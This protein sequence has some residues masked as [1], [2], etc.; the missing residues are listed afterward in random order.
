MPGFFNKRIKTFAL[1]LFLALGTV[2]LSAEAKPFHHKE[3]GI[4]FEVPDTWS[5]KTEKA[6][7]M[8]MPKDESFFILFKVSD[9]ES[10]DDFEAEIQ[11]YLGQLGKTM[12][13][14]NA[15][16]GDFKETEINGLPV[17][18]VEGTGTLEDNEV[19][20]EVSVIMATKPVI[21]FS[22]ADTKEMEAH[23]DEMAEFIQSIEPLG[24]E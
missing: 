21:V 5:V 18:Y 15:E 6:A 7:L 10:K 13:I 11:E 12:H 17:V 3:A 2:T 19:N 4:Q 16:T 22:L 8:V 14:E 23:K 1:S 20:F 24:S 9:A